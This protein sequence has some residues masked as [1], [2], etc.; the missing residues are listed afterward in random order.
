MRCLIII[1]A[2]VAVSFFLSNCDSPVVADR[3]GISDSSSI[4]K[5]TDTLRDTS[6]NGL[7]API[8][9]VNDFEKILD[10]S[11]EALLDTMIASFERET[12]IEIAI[13]TVDTG[14]TTKDKFDNYAHGIS[15]SWGVGKRQKNNGILICVSAG[16]KRIRINNGYGIERILSNEETKQLIDNEFIPYFSK[17]D[18]YRGINN[19]L[20]KMIA[21]LKKNMNAASD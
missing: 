2:I 10:S 9:W 16:H 20:R 1:T 4:L 3:S 19:G 12:G 17:G 21:K 7:P 13:V 15:N 6:E 5:S 14:M 8:G 18:H 11:E